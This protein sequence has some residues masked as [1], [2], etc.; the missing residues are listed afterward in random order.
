[1]NKE[2]EEDGKSTMNYTKES[3]VFKGGVKQN[4]A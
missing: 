1:M 4:G 2:T 3:K